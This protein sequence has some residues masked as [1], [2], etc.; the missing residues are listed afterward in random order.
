[1]NEA[2]PALVDA[3]PVP[4]TVGDAMY[5]GLVQCAPETSLRTVAALMA[6]AQVHCVVV[7]EDPGD[8]RSLW[9][10]VS[11][12]DLVAAST[13]RSLDEQLASGTAMKPAVTAFPHESLASAAKRMAMH[14]MS[15]LVVV[16]DARHRPVGVLSTLDLARMLGARA[17]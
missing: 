2:A 15:H 16:D 4:A 17:M 12:L 7:I 8:R 11:H 13:V 1:M 10:V 6:E 3:T 14:S 5:W 9:G